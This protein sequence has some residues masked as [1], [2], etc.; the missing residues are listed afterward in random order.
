VTQSLTR[1]GSFTI[2]DARYVASKMGA[3]LRNLNARYGDPDLETIPD[4]VEESALLIAAGYL[5]TVDFGYKRG[6][7]WKL[8]LRYTA[9]IGGHLRDDPPGCFPDLSDVVGLQFYSY[10]TYSPVFDAL[11]PAKRNAFKAT[12]P[13]SRTGAPEPNAAGGYSTDHHYSRN[14]KGLSRNVYQAL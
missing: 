6:D 8:R 1:T 13:I 5:N 11:D 10:L 12:L 14:G 2:T 4:Y 3:D 9:T 7:Q